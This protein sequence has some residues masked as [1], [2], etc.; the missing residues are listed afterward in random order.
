VRLLLIEILR[1]HKPWQLLGVVMLAFLWYL[2]GGEDDPETAPMALGASMTAVYMMGGGGFTMMVP[3]ALSYLPLSRRDIWRANWLAATVWPT[4]LAT[5]TML[6]MMLLPATRTTVGFSRIPLA[7]AYGFAYAGVWSVL[8]MLMASAAS[9]P[10]IRR[11][12]GD[13]ITAITPLVT[14]GGFYV[15]FW[16]SRYVSLPTRWSEFS[17][18]G[19]FLLASTIGLVMVMY[20]YSPPVT[21]KLPLRA[22]NRRGAAERAASRPLS[23]SRLTGLPRLLW[24]EYAW[25]MAIAGAVVVG[26]AITVVALDTFRN[27]QQLAAGVVRAQLLQLFDSNSAGP[28]FGFGYIFWLMMYFLASVARFGSIIRHLRVLPVRP[29][30]LNAI[31]VA[32]PAAVLVTLWGALLAAYVLVVG[33][34]VTSLSLG[35]LLSLIGASALTRSIGLRWEHGWAAVI[36]LALMSS[37]LGVLPMPRLPGQELFLSGVACLVAAALLNRAT[38]GHSAAYRRPTMAIGMPPPR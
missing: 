14:M 7:A 21:G 30:Q 28:E 11:W 12:L 22:G 29:L 8:V 19:A 1:R 6:V 35:L 37:V 4:V 5:A 27:T 10:R 2:A 34:P 24:N 38:L 15:G 9:H 36:F 16:G 3:Q 33:Q 23:S 25:T 20:F 13:P 18:L 17:P 32:W 31:F 26:L